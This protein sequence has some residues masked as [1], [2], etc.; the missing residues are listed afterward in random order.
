M[1]DPIAHSLSPAMH[2]AAF[3]SR[4]MM[5]YY[6]PVWCPPNAL[7]KKLQAFVTLGGQGIN[8]TRPLKEKAWPIVHSASRWAEQAG[9]VNTL[10][11]TDQGWVGDNTDVQALWQLLP[12]AQSGQR[13][14]ILGA[15]G[16]ARASAVALKRRGY[17][18]TVARR[19]QVPVSWADDVVDWAQRLDPYAWAVVVNATPVGQEGEGDSDQKWPR[20]TSGSIAVEWVY[21]PRET[22]F[23]RQARHAGAAVVDGLTLLVEQARLSWVL[24]FGVQAPKDVMWA[25]VSRWQ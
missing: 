7:E 2:N 22:T 23:V 3:Q 12:V 6:V 4:G 24:W 15:G 18:V 5:A 10:Q 17:R 21:R 11:W 8:L 25:A 16:V 19:R 14:L 20:L 13:A 9:A 1:G